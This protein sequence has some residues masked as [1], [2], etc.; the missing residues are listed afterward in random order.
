M[1][2][3]GVDQSVDYYNFINDVVLLIQS[4]IIACTFTKLK[5]SSI[6]ISIS[7]WT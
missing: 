6:I 2:K 7:G 3:Q 4:F 5:F 1:S